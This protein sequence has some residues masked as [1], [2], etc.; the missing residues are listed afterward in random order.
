MRRVLVSLVV[1]TLLASATFPAG[2]AGAERGATQ[3]QV[4][5]TVEV[6]SQDGGQ[7]A[8]ATIN[9]T[10]GDGE[11]TTVTTAS[12][13]KAFVD[14]PRGSPVML[15]VSSERF[16]R[17]FPVFVDEATGQE[18]TVEVAR[19]GSA[20]VSLTSPSG[21]VDSASVR[22]VQAG[23][24]VASGETDADG[25]F[26]TGVVEQGRYTL[27][28]GKPTYYTNRTRVDVDSEDTEVEVPMRTGATQV[29]VLVVDDHFDDPR[30]VNNATVQFGD[31]GTVRTT[32]GT[33]VFAVAVNTRH[34]VRAT[35][36]EYDTARRQYS[37]DESSD[38]IRLTIQ[39]E[40]TLVVQPTNRQVVVGEST[41]LDVVDAYGDP[42]ANATISLDGESVAE[43]DDDGEARVTIE[44]GGNHT[45]T[46]SADGVTSAEVTV[47]GVNADGSTLSPTPTITSTATS[48]PTETPVPTTT[49]VSLPGFG[50]LAAVLGVVLAALVLARRD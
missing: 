49:S 47:V 8:G 37:V 20:T 45:L 25:T 22:L 4:T 46:A 6:I 39:R 18:V 1:V 12:N 10:W 15:S 40:P 36:P 28:T 17:N 24:R 38:S 26:S 13:G 44:S 21:P 19:K 35:Q 16:I 32:G 33:A 48:E 7:V 43:T 2:V 27:V 41:A 34:T 31:V 5:L 50:P 30:P 29:E 14:V 3:E 42:V 23:E 11:G 9:A